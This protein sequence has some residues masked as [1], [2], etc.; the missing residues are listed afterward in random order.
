MK[1]FLEEAVHAHSR[2]IEHG[3]KVL[4]LG[5]CFSENIYEKGR[6]A[7]LSFFNTAFGTLFHPIPIAN[8]LKQS[9]EMSSSER[10]FERDGKFYSW[11][12]Y[13]K[14]NAN[15]ENELASKLGKE[16]EQ[17]R[18][19][20]SEAKYIFITFGSAKAYLLEDKVVANCH[21][22]PSNQFVSELTNLDALISEYQKLIELL[23]KHYPQL[24]VV[25]TVSPVRHAK[26]GLIVNNRSKAR[27][28]MLCE[29][30]A[31]LE[32]V[33]Y[34]PAYEMIIDELRD[35]RF[36][37][38]DLVHPN[39]AGIAYVW[40]KFQETFFT[41]KTNDLAKEVQKF[42]AFFNHIVLKEEETRKE[43]DKRRIK[44]EEL[45]TFLST[46]PKILW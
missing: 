31:R 18:E 15:T 19:V 4:F 6:N 20:L 13:T 23:R 37:E 41:E 12:S 36:Y 21:K 33:S 35:Y 24:E 38:S 29:E 43:K 14:F 8:V 10:I 7:G 25:L 16:R 22:W 40:Q 17:I 27:L 5:S 30:L 28:L 1:W 3:D 46:H 32:G 44:E 11:D 9:I 2:K 45:H 34:F 39:S 42:R 26:D